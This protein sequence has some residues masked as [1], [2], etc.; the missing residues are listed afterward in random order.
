[1]RRYAFPCLPPVICWASAPTFSE[2]MW[3]QH[4]PFVS[5]ANPSEF[6]LQR[7]SFSGGP[8]ELGLQRVI[9]DVAIGS[10]LVQSDSK[11]GEPLLFQV[12]LPDCVRERHRAVNTWV[13]LLDAQAR[14]VFVSCPRF[15]SCSNP[16]TDTV[17]RSVQAQ[18]AS[19]PSEFSSIMALNPRI[20]S[21]SPSS[22]PAVAVS[23]ISAAR[24]P[25]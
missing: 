8:L 15:L 17:C 3:R 18:Q 10:L 25:R 5:T 4:P 14:R 24:S 11:T 21:L 1:M 9:N 23:H 19:W 2:P 16:H 20:S 7:I 12:K 6:V 22:L 13:F